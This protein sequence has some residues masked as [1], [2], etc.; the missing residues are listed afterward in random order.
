MKSEHIPVDSFV[1]SLNAE[2]NRERAGR[3]RKGKTRGGGGAVS[4]ALFCVQKWR[5]REKSNLAEFTQ[6]AK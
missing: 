6:T 4:L 3:Q 1:Q 2:K 5:G